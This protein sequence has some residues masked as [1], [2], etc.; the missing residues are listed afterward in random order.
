MAHMLEIK[1]GVAS[2]AYNGETP[3]HGLG[4]KVP[5]DL[6]PAQMCEAGGV[7]WKVEKRQTSII[8][9]GKKVFT[10]AHSLVRLPNGRNVKEESILTFL[11]SGKTWH[12]HQNEEAFEFFNEF[13]ASGD[14]TME[15]AGSLKEGRYVWAL[16]RIKESFYVVKKKDEVQSYLLFTNPHEFGKSIDVRFTPVRVV[17]NNTLTLALDAKASQR[18]ASSHRNPFDATAVKEKLGLASYKLGQYKERAQFLATKRYTVEQ[19]KEYF[20]TVFPANES[21]AKEGSTRTAK[22][23]HKGAVTGM[24]IV[25]QQPGADIAPGTFW[26]L[27]NA[28]TFYTNHL[29]GKREDTRVHSLW[30]GDAMKQN[31]LALNTAVEMAN[32]A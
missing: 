29:A 18:V 2:M 16:A 17:C 31:Q 3:W 8:L 13:V 19:M 6:T 10:P 30:Y 22:E 26:N 20:M 24:A 11:P 28:A 32:A 23:L 25:D 21:R 12:E 1:D 5:A 4:K 9:N 15:T 14:M 7:D 27:F